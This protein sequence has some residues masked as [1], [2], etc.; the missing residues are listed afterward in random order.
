MPLFTSFGS[1]AS[2]IVPSWF[3]SDGSFVT[4]GSVA[5]GFNW[6]GEPATSQ[7]SDARDQKY[8][9]RSL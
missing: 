4:P 6:L 2:E 8:A 3:E 7:P 9:F 1:L 5:I